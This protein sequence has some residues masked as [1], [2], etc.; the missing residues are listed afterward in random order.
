MKTHAPHP[1]RI[2]AALLV[3]LA[4]LMFQPDARGDEV[5]PPATA[6]GLCNALLAAMKQGPS[7]GFAG[8]KELLGP[9]IRN[10][11]DLALMTRIVVGPCWK[12]LAPSDCDQLVEAFSEYSIDTYADQFSSYS[13]QRFEVDPNPTPTPK[14]DTIVHT[15]LFTGGADPVQLDYLMRKTGDRWRIIDV[16]L[17]GT[18]SQMAARRS[19][20]SGILSQGG[21]PALVALLRKKAVELSK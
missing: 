12:T 6:T 1:G 7:L 20:Y 17:N 13:G 11:L 18:I 15:K 2:L 8:R 9:E 19:E 5:A 16:Y 21:A 3:A 14:G 4:T 10:D